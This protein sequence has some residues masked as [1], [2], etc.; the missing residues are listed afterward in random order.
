MRGLWLLALILFLLPGN[1]YAQPISQFPVVL[2]SQA[3]NLHPAEFSKRRATWSMG[4]AQVPA[5]YWILLAPL[6][7]AKYEERTES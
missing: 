6:Q 2:I 7:G 1:A 4:K 3:V 5:I